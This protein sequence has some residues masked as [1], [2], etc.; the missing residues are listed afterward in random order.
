MKGLQVNMQTR[1][2]VGRS[3]R[4][5]IYLWFCLSLISERVGR[6]AER[7]A[8]GGPTAPELLFWFFWAGVCV[9]ARACMCVSL[10]GSGQMTLASQGEQDLGGSQFWAGGLL[11]APRSC[12][13]GRRAPV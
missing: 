11:S 1:R 8:W 3:W 12:F 2:A 5:L 10:G 9:C 6:W 7:R 4:V 13:L